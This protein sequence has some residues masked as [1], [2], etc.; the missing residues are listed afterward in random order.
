MNQRVLQNHLPENK[1]T[2]GSVDSARKRALVCEV[3][4]GEEPTERA[5][6]KRQCKKRHRSKERDECA[7]KASA[8]ED[9]SLE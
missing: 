7:T 1:N 3:P 5:A 6:K 9:E 2:I 4:P 8:E